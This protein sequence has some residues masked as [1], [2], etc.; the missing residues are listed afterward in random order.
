M[1]R[2]KEME[3][4]APEKQGEVEG[5]EGDGFPVLR[6]N[7]AGAD[8]GAASHGICAPRLRWHGAGGGKIRGVHGGIGKGGPVDAGA[9]VGIG[10]HRK[11]RRLLDA[12]HEVTL[13]RAPRPQQRRVSIC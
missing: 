9:P 11:H 3:P 5:M 4:K 10:G 12:P 6:R 13:K 7:V 1:M 2:P 8:L